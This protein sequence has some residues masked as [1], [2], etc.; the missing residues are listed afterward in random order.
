MRGPAQLASSPR[1]SAARRRKSSSSC[2]ASSAVP[3]SGAGT[4]ASA[5]SCCASAPTLALARSAASWAGCKRCVARPRAR[6]IEIAPVVHVAPPSMRFTS[7]IASCGRSRASRWRRASQSTAD[8]A[9]CGL[10]DRAER[11]R[12]VL[13]HAGVG[14][15]VRQR[16]PHR[17]RRCARATHRQLLLGQASER[18]AQGAFEQRRQAGVPGERLQLARASPKMSARPLPPAR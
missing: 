13:A 18:G 3:G 17:A 16:L 2:G 11:N 6:A 4:S 7:A 12:L 15:D 10:G 8:R 9:V 14:L 1:R 5:T